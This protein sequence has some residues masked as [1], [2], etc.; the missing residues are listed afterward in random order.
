V[1][2]ILVFIDFDGVIH[3]IRGGRPSVLDPLGD[4][5]KGDWSHV[6]PLAAV[7]ADFPESRAVASSHWR[8]FFPIEDIRQM[9]HPIRVFD[10]TGPDGYTRYREIADFMTG[11]STCWLAIDDCPDGMWP[12]EERWRLIECKPWLGLGDPTHL[13]ELRAKLEICRSSADIDEV[14]RRVAEI[15]QQVDQKDFE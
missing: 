15:T 13:E 14:K 2:P 4:W 7:L 8:L 11:S 10:T 3:P 9:L 5:R 6:K 1:N 12:D